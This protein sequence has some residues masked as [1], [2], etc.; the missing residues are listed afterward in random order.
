[1]VKG[2]HYNNLLHTIYSTCCTLSMPSQH[3]T[4]VWIP[5]EARMAFFSPTLCSVPS[6]LP[7][8]SS[9]MTQPSLDSWYSA[10]RNTVDTFKESIG[11]TVE[12]L[13]K[14]HVGDQSLCP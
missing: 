4:T 13:N 14:G 6:W 5:A 1:M 9:V 2:H 12:P 10:W 11:H 7:I 8:A 3:M